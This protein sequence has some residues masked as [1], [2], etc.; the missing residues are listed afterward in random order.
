[1]AH[2]PRDLNDVAEAASEAALR[3]FLTLIDVDLDNVRE[4]RELRED[5]HYA[6]IQ[7][8]GR[9][10]AR[11]LMRK[12]L[13]GLLMLGIPAA[14]MIIWSFAKEGFFQWLSKGVGG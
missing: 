14:F 10:E 1:M 8:K 9:D 5:L 2:D 7:R 12:G 11:K 3:K 13:Y 4:I 6:R